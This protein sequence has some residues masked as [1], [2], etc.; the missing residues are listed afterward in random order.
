MVVLAW[1]S[2]AISCA[3]CNRQ[4]RPGRD[5]PAAQPERVILVGTQIS[6]VKPLGVDRI[7][8][9][10]ASA[11]MQVW[12]LDRQPTREVD[13]P[14]PDGVSLFETYPLSP[15]LLAWPHWTNRSVEIGELPSG[16][17][18]CSF[19]VEKGSQ[20]IRLAVSRSGHLVSWIDEPF[21]DKGVCRIRLAETSTGNILLDMPVPLSWTGQMFDSLAISPDASVIAFG[22]GWGS[23]DVGVVDIK[24]KAILWRKRDVGGGFRMCFAPDSRSLFG[25]DAAGK[26]TQY[27]TAT[28]KVLWQVTVR[29][30]G[31]WER[32]VAVDVSPDGKRVA[33]GCDFSNRAI[34]WNIDSRKEIA[35]FKASKYPLWCVFFD[36]SGEG[37]WTAGTVD[38]VISYYPLPTASK[39]TAP[40][41]S[42]APA[43]TT[44]PARNG[45]GN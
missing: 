8:V 11:R 22:Y 20:I 17:V 9:F 45:L 7:A 37:I 10:T 24:T 6:D 28:G 23:P 41:T 32:L 44:S 3:C 34:V 1:A 31:E 35:S 4:S 27:E 26:L 30:P 38:S 36:P 42:S 16:K 5:D 15:T 33:V 13:V 29:S 18:I 25:A 43:T 19:P 40:A 21:A 14:V 12:T 39:P 2:V